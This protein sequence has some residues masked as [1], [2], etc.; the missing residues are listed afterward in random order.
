MTNLPELRKRVRSARRRLEPETRA[1]AAA[2]LAESVASLEVFA[3]AHSIAAYMANEGELDLQPVVERAW[4]AGKEVY[5]PIISSGRRLRFCRFRR[6]TVLR[7][8]TFGILEPKAEES[9]MIAVEAIDLVLTPLVAFD[10]QCNRVGM[11]GGY[12]DRTFGFLKGRGSGATPW[13]LGIAYELQK[14]SRIERQ[15][16]DLPLHAVATDT[17]LYFPPDSPSNTHRE[18]SR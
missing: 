1:Y 8:R 9:D 15:P 12:Y 14:V 10:P 7:P 6:D 18:S 5:L 11:G 2:E 17:Q 3:R 16:W 13:M 4:E